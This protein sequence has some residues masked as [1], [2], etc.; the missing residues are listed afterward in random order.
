MESE[1]LLD[2]AG[3]RGSPAMLSSFDEDGPARNKGPRHPP[4]PPTMKESSR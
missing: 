2:G 1:A 4:A 3:R